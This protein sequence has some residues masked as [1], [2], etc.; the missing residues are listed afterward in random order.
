MDKYEIQAIE[1]FEKIW[2]TEGRKLFNGDVSPSAMKDGGIVPVDYCISTIAR[3]MQQPHGSEIVTNIRSILFNL[4]KAANEQF[5]YPDESLHVS[6]LGCTQREKS[7]VFDR[8]HI[9]KIKDI[10]I[11]EIQKT[12]A[13]EIL[14]KGVGVIGNQIFIQGIPLNKNWEDLRR[15]FDEKLTSKGENPISY[16]D[17]SPIHVN[18]IRIINSDIHLLRSLHETISQLRDIELGVIKLQTIEV[19]ITDFCV[20][21]KNVVWLDK[22]ECSNSFS[23]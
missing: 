9:K 23:I 17:K 1:R 21:K 13:A 16:E 6:L 22:I 19:V 11:Q 7:N 8:N 15:L 3:L 12:E 14:L 2:E 20:S 4:F 18:I 5:I 10:A